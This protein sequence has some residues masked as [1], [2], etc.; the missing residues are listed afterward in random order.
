M[1]GG[2]G[3]MIREKRG[4]CEIEVKGDKKR[5]EGVFNR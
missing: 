4:W 3:R 2:N 5:G 1:D